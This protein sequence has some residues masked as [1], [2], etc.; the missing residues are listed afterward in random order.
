MRLAR[1]GHEPAFDEIV[2]RYRRPLVAFAGAIAGAGRAEDVVQAGLMRAH[3]ALAADDR[4]IRLRPWL[5]AIV[6][7]GALNAVRDEPAWSELDPERQG[8]RETAAT[9][10]QRE[11]LE[12]LVDA[13]CALPESQRQALVMREME[14][15]GHA[16]IAAKLRTSPTAVRGLIFRARTTL[17]NALGA[18]VP[19]PVLRWLLEDTAAA[20]AAGAAGAGGAGAGAGAV[21]AGGGALKGGAL[22]KAAV[23]LTAAVVAIGAGKAIQDRRS[24]DERPAAG[25]ETA[26]AAT[27]TGHRSGKG[28]GGGNGSAA[29]TGPAGER[30][31]EA[32]REGAEERDERRDEAG[33][34]RGGDRSDGRGGGGGGGGEGGGSSGSSGSSSSG[35][36]G[37]G[38]GGSGG[39]SGSSGGSDDDDDE[40][41]DEIDDD[42]RF[43]P[44]EPEEPEELD[45]DGD[46]DHSGP[47]SGDGDDD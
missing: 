23:G 24:G 42:D 9:A 36:G 33:D 13:V 14:G 37:G 3:D 22:G 17:R 44:E 18:L 8:G 27:G 11:E 43:E 28:G 2:R 34:E 46:G 1:E 39:H 19:L 6:R 31:R 16:E 12:R 10:E 45:D 26:S 47:G 20:A 41:D 32:A 4:E 35:G 15:V 40:V 30:R 5:F 7:N 29:G 38:N 25:P 21:G